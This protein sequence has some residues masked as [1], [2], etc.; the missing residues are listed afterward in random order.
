MSISTGVREGTLKES[1]NEASHEQR[2]QIRF[3]YE[4]YQGGRGVESFLSPWKCTYSLSK[5]GTKSRKR[6]ATILEE[7]P[8]TKVNQNLGH[9]HTQGNRS[10]RTCLPFCAFRCIC[11]RSVSTLTRHLM[12]YSASDDLLSV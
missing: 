4:K 1:A 8:D 10:Q 7:K 5:P 6:S 12:T 11:S 9:I 2:A 3:M